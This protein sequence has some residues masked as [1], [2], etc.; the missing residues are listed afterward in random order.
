ML[1]ILGLL[2]W[3]LFHPRED[4]GPKILILIMVFLAIGPVCNSVMNAENASFPQKFDYFLYVVDQNLGISAFS[5]ARIPAEWQRSVLFQL[6]ES[7][8][9]AMVVWYG[10]NLKSREGRPNKLL[11]AYAVTFLVGPCLY[12]ILPACGPRH[13]FGSAFPAGNPVV[14]L[15]LVQVD[16]WPNAIPSLH[17]STALLF[18]LFAGK[19]RILRGIAWVYVGGTVAATLA[20]EHYLIDLVV[21]VPFACFVTRVAEGKM[22]Q[23]AYHLLVV[24]AWMLTI[25]YAT[26]ALVT[27]PAVLR[28]AAVSTVAFAAFSMREAR[29]QA[30]GVAQPSPMVE[31]ATATAQDSVSGLGR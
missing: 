4:F 29:R 15:V 30:P 3:M 9:L 25:R 18:V 2:I 27:W 21:A 22:R 17:V 1:G 6:Y 23:A 19:G 8:T 11:I 13:A 16:R 31:F 12:L 26:P 5:L 28:I 24:L 7:L 10:V 14:A 20:F